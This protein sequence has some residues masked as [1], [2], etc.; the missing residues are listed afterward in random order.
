MHQ[1]EY[2]D[3][4]R[5]VLRDTAG[6]VISMYRFMELVLGLNS[7]PWAPPDY[8][9]GY[10]GHKGYDFGAP[11]YSEVR[12][13]CTGKVVVVRGIYDGDGSMGNSVCIEE[14]GQPDGD[15][16]RTHRYMHFVQYP[17]VELG[18]IVEQGTLLGY[19]GTTGESSGNH[20]HYDVTTGGPWGPR[21][22]AWDQFNHSSEP[23]GWTPQEITNASGSA[24]GTNLSWSVIGEDTGINYGPGEPGEDAS[25]PKTYYTTK[26]VL[27]VDWTCVANIGRID[28]AQLGGLI[29]QVGSLSNES[30]IIGHLT[31]FKQWYSEY[32]GLIPLGFYLYSYLSPDTS[33]SELK[34]K[35]QIFLSALKQEGILP[36]NAQLGVWLRLGDD[37]P[38]STTVAKN[39]QQI[40]WFREVLASANFKTTGALLSTNYIIQH[41]QVNDLVSIPIWIAAWVTLD[42][43][44][45]ANSGDEIS[46]FVPPTIYSALSSS[47]YIWQDGSVS[48][49]QGLIDHNWVIQAIPG[50]GYNDDEISPSFPSGGIPEI[51]PAKRLFFEPA[52]GRILTASTQLS[53]T[54]DAENVIISLTFDNSVPKVITQAESE[55]L[56]S[57]YKTLPRQRIGQNLYVRARAYDAKTGRLVAKGSACYAW[58]WDRPVGEPAS[59][60][61][62]T[63][64]RLPYLVQDN[65]PVETV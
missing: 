65:S 8:W 26:P 14:L 45:V 28:T 6:T 2:D 9:G 27:D 64:L 44:S 55:A 25:A 12:S 42:G 31:D 19:V 60:E 63:T 10:S 54:T 62:S 15:S 50:A 1:N 20:L 36:S 3:T 51:I 49:S 58:R 17:E 32:A 24:W 61:A 39:V 59:E 48:Y 23:P 40:T 43:T 16:V 41:T 47:I 57:T 53:I 13:T 22:D 7:H 4:G 56:L 34:R 38:T 37:S 33:E 11:A 30:D 21:I 18:D 35:Y 52:P 29:I 5:I 46:A